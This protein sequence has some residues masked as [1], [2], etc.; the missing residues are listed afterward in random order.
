MTGDSWSWDGLKR[1]RAL[2]GAAPLLAFALSGCAFSFEDDDGGRQVVGVFAVAHE[3]SGAEAAAGDVHRFQFYGVWVD[4]AFRGTSVAVGEVQMTVADLRNQWAAK[5]DGA[6]SSPAADDACAA[7]V[8][9]GFRWCSLPAAA[10]GRAGELF[11][12]AVAGVSIGVGARDRH[13]GV[14]YHRQTLLE[15]TNENAL[16]AWPALP[17]ALNVE[18]A[19]ASVRDLLRGSING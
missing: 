16:I 4:D 10:P 5:P 9:F 14:G 3:A 19:Q 2:R 13:V 6:T 7:E 12:I 15:V 8:G 17:A 1:L 18:P 11:D